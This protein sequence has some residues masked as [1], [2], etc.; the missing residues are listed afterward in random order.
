MHWEVGKGTGG[1]YTE[2]RTL[3]L[4]Q[5]LR[6]AAALARV[7]TSADCPAHLLLC[8]SCEPEGENGWYT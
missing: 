1:R 6:M 7:R 8:G 4:R 3:A 5:I 2:H